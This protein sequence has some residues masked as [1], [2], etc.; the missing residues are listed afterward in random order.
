MIM[1]AGMENQLRKY[2]RIRD[3]ITQLNANGDKY[4]RYISMQKQT[5]AHDG[6]HH[7]GAMTTNLS[8]SFNGI[9]KSARNLPITALVEL[10]YYRC[11]AYFGDRYT[12]AHAEVTASKLFTAYAKNKFNKQG[13]KTPKHLVTVFSHKDGR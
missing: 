12:K 8:E 2:Q 3:R 5:L 6:G 13:K 7:Y 4:L 9:L 1:W 11:V 10:T